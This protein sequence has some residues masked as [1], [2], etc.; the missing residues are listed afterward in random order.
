MTGI[1]NAVEIVAELM[2]LSARTAPKARGS[3]SIVI[4]AIYCEDLARLAGEMRRL[5]DA[6]GMKFL[7]RDAGNLEKSDACVLIG[8]EKAAFAGL[9]CDGCGYETCKEMAAAQK[10]TK[11]TKK[12]FLGPNCAIKMTD[13]GIALGSAAKTASLHNVDNRIMFSAGVGALS[14]GLLEGCSVAYGIP[15]KASGKSIYFDRQS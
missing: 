2:A 11:E 9:N 1:S 6:L 13:I 4:R 12:P 15:L 7:L 5:G 8:C 14:L 3:D 10:E